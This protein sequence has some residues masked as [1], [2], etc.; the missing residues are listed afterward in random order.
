M[1]A[2]AAGGFTL[3]ELLIII[4]IIALLLGILVP[5]L[6]G[7]YRQVQR[8][9][10]LAN[11]KQWY[12]AVCGY[13][14][15]NDRYFPENTASPARHISW[16]GDTVIQF[17]KDYLIEWDKQNIQ[18]ARYDILHCPTQYWHRHDGALRNLRGL[19]G[20]FYMPHRDNTSW[21]TMDY[22]PAGKDWVTKR[23]FGENPR[24]P[25]MADMKQYAGWIPSW[26]LSDGTPIS[27][28]RQ[29]SGEPYGGNFLFEDGST[30]WYDTSEITL[31]GTIGGWRCYYNVPL[32]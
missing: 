23:R 4:A 27:S 30:E 21:N 28:H 2:G 18:E 15:D 16:C 1:S 14:G 5:S 19:C 31:G 11:V 26:Y 13:G 9:K 20:Y 12:N 10:C 22:T 24:T 3:L 7:A 8:A 29:S 32:Q 6:T 25:I 17:W